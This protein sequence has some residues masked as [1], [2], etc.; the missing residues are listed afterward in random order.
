MYSLFPTHTYIS[1]QTHSRMQ[2]TQSPHIG[3]KESLRALQHITQ[4]RKCKHTQD[5][6]P[7]YKT[8]NI[9]HSIW[10]NQSVH[11]ATTQNCSKHTVRLN[12]WWRVADRWRSS[13]VFRQVHM[14]TAQRVTTENHT[15]T[16]SHLLP[17]T[18]KHQHTPKFAQ[19]NTYSHNIVIMTR[20]AVTSCAN[21]TSDYIYTHIQTHIYMIYI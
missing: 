7:A 3:S 4:M 2:P 11:E 8:F 18:S 14:Q 21:L 16:R 20:R 9:K 1:T 12:R 15:L 17:K 6:T 13:L 10:I 19:T 5:C